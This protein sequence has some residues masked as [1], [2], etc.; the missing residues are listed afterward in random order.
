LSRL[1]RPGRNDGNEA[2]REF[3]ELALIP[4]R[5]AE[6]PPARRVINISASGSLPDYANI[7]SAD[8]DFLSHRFNLAI[9]II[10]NLLEAFFALS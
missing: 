5:C 3:F 9:K 2:I 10:T 4:K 1:K 8:F 7:P 6:K